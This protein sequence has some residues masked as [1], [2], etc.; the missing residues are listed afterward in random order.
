VW[1]PNKIEKK[2]PL[3]GKKSGNYRSTLA[4]STNGTLLNIHYFPSQLFV[5][6]EEIMFENFKIF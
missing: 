1:L 3:H 6:L 2:K 4:I 5:D